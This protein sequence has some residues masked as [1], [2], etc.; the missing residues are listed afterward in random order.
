MFA[1]SD[2]MAVGALRGLRALGKR[3]PDDVALIGY[4]D[5]DFAAALA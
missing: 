2:L 4:D 3:V 1:A 5:I